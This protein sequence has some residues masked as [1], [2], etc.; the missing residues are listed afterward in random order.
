MMNRTT[1]LAALTAL[2]LLGGGAR[3]AEH[4]DTWITT[5]VK[6][7]LASHKDVS[8]VHTKVRTNGG[9]VTLSGRARST[10]EKELAERYARGIDGVQDVHNR[11]VVMPPRSNGAASNEDR[12]GAGSRLL[13]NIDDSTITGRVKASLAGDRGTS[14]L[15]TEVDTKNGVVTLSGTASSD[16]ERT[17]AERLARD[18]KG[19]KS[20]D[21]RIEVK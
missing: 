3:A 15:H 20:V 16:A 5:K 8:A 14:A 2:S 12:H 13:D 21:N 6:S 18:A 11:I 17:L 1:L 4:S 10:A 7:T 9:V 19:V